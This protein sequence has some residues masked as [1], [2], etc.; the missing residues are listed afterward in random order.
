MGW[1]MGQQT[2]NGLSPKHQALEWDAG[3]T[4]FPI[5]NRDA[6]TG[7]MVVQIPSQA[8]GGLPPPPFKSGSLPSHFQLHIRHHVCSHPFGC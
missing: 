5:T 7:W 1:V 2:H 3:W 8:A 6:G 4:S